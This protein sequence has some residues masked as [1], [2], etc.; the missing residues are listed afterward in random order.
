MPLRIR[1]A[2]GAIHYVL[3]NYD[4]ALGYF[5]GAARDINFSKN[6]EPE[7][8]ATYYRHYGKCLRKL[9]R[10]YEAIEQFN[11]CKLTALKITIHEH[12]PIIRYVNFF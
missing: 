11:N 2:F 6:Q 9:D 3:K 5:R 12:P 8:L 1:D 7:A 4:T 10:L